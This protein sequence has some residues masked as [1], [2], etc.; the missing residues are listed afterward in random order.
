MILQSELQNKEVSQNG[1]DIRLW[2]I[3]ASEGY[4]AKRFKKRVISRNHID[5]TVAETNPKSTFEVDK[6]DGSSSS[7]HKSPQETESD[8]TWKDLETALHS[9]IDNPRYAQCSQALEFIDALIDEVKNVSWKEH[10]T[11]HFIKDFLNIVVSNSR[12]RTK[13]SSLLDILTAALEDDSTELEDD[14]DRK[15]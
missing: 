2:D 10:A 9:G 4:L 5:D 15:E 6:I 11:I 7:S 12:A 13:F 14:I 1:Y 8:N 3:L